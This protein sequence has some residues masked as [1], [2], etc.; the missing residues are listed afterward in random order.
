MSVNLVKLC[1][2][3]SSIEGLKEWVEHKALSSTDQKRQEIYH[4]TRMYP[5]RE[6]ELLNE[7]S[8][9]WII[10]G[11]LC[12]RQK[13]ISLTSI[14][15]EEG[16]TRCRIGLKPE[17]VSVQT[18]SYRP[19]Q[20]WRYLDGTATP[21]DISHFEGDDPLPEKLRNELQSLGLL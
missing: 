16:I 12:C 8:L 6:K 17:V 21:P 1:V 9:Y 15:D 18:R 2:G 3:C 4:I 10:K 19:F 11:L 5:K 13:I 14:R 20:G 7:G